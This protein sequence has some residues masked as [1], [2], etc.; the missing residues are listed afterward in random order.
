MLKK[1]TPGISVTG[2][3]LERFKNGTIDTAVRC[4]AASIIEPL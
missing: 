4:A 2:A 3:L 1:S